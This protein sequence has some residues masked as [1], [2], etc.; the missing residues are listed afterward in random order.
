ML[1]RLGALLRP[2]SMRKRRVMPPTPQSL[3]QTDMVS[4]AMAG[5]GLPVQ[6]PALERLGD[7]TVTAP[8][9]V[10]QA[11]RAWAALLRVQ[12]VPPP[13]AVPTARTDR[14]ATTPAG[15]WAAWSKKACCP[16]PIR[17]GLT[18]AMGS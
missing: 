10:A 6:P 16:A 7:A 9:R 5:L 1:I 13:A 15:R 3:Q 8:T 18:M 14:T 4:L 2:P 17:Q 12:P 11:R